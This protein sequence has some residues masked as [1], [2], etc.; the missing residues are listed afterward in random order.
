MSQPGR[1][2][3]ASYGD[4]ESQNYGTDRGLAQSLYARKVTTEDNN[5]ATNRGCSNSETIS[6]ETKTFEIKKNIL[7]KQF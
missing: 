5:N 6:E 7:Y 4:G 1:T 3:G 2:E